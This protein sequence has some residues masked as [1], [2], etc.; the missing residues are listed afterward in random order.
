M[1]E[2]GIEKVEPAGKD[3]AKVIAKEL[4]QLAKSEDKA[5]KEGGKDEE[6]GGSAPQDG[7]QASEGL[8]NGD[9]G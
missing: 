7:F 5:A 1:A 6:G 9:E 4:E 3:G 8:K 2:G